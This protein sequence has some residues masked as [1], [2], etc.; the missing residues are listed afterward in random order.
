[1]VALYIV[2]GKSQCAEN[3][4]SSARRETINGTPKGGLHPPNWKDLRLSFAR[5]LKTIVQHFMFSL[6]L[7]SIVVAYGTCRKCLKRRKLLQKQ[8]PAWTSTLD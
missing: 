5:A 4:C 8:T 2:Y 3:D 7:I 6:K 1:M